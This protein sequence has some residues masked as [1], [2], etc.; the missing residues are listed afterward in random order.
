[1]SMR[2]VGM[3]LWLG[4]LMLFV[5]ASADSASVSAMGREVVNISLATNKLMK[6]MAGI[7]GFCAGVTMHTVAIL[8]DNLKR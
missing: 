7:G 6:G 3:I 2:I 4:G 5:S 8:I 1:M